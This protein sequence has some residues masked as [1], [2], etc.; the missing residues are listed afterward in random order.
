MLARLKSLFTSNEEDNLF[1]FPTIVI[2]ELKKYPDL[3]R[4][5]HSREI[6]G[7]IMTN[8][9]SKEE[10]ES[11][12]KGIASIPD[13]KRNPILGG[14]VFPKIFAQVVL[15]KHDSEK[16]R[17]EFMARYFTESEKTNA[18]FKSLIGVDFTARLESFFAKISG[19][20]KIG[21]PKGYDQ[22]GNYANA[23]VR[24][25]FP[26]EGFISVH[27]GNYF[28]KEFEA[29]YTHLASQVNVM[30]QLSYFVTINQ[31][32]E[33]GELTLFDL[34]WKD[35]H[36]KASRTED[37]HVQLLNGK[38]ADV[39]KSGSVKRQY[40]NP[41]EGAILLFAGGQIWHRV[42]PVK[43]KK[44]RITIAGFMGFSYDDQEVLYWS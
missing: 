2:S 26:N 31:P 35:A 38:L 15:Q 3:L 28:Q 40:M 33:G 17:Q 13:D 21:V 5:I 39:Q 27:S 12:R 18:N 32:E 42:E 23:T 36:G 44:S 24:R 16:L 8:V 43:G 37:K 4:S 34:E 30:N 9:L 14:D 29:F 20:R 6:D 7:M 41:P 22:I 19:G 25:Y 1:H 11:I 10:V